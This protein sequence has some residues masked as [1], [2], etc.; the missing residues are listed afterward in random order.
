[1]LT[2]QEMVRRVNSDH[3]TVRAMFLLLEGRGLVARERHPSDSRARCVTL[4]VKGRQ[5][6][7]KVWTKSEPLRVRTAGAFLPDEVTAPLG[8]LRR[9]REVMVPPVSNGSHTTATPSLPA[10]STIE[11]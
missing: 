2:Q 6:F 4:T 1:V 10:R 5:V 8:L 11:D 9:V 7:R 3:N